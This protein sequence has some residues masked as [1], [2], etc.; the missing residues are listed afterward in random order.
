MG[1][2][3]GLRAQA[4]HDYLTYHAG[5]VTRQEIS[6]G[7]GIPIN[8]VC[9]LVDNLKQAGKVE[10]LKPSYAP[11]TGQVREV[12]ALTGSE[13]R[14]RR[15]V[16]QSACDFVNE[17][18]LEEDLKEEVELIKREHPEHAQQVDKWLNAY[19][20]DATLLPV[21]RT[22]EEA[23]EQHSL[24]GARL[25]NYGPAMMIHFILLEGGAIPSD[26]RDDIL[27]GRETIESLFGR[28]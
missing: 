3:K 17:H 6:D 10:V 14:A 26:A 1:E 27:E 12:L 11:Q 7:T 24:G 16:F 4:V 15:S 2:A 20:D 22:Y 28:P 13:A 23:I 25:R 5:G 9:S 18:M 8:A 21:P 19:L